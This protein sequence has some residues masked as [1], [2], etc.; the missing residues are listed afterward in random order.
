MLLIF[1][2]ETITP[3]RI[4]SRAGKCPTQGAS[5]ASSVEPSIVKVLPD[6]ASLFSQAIDPESGEKICERSGKCR[7]DFL[8]AK[9]EM[10]EK[11]HR[12]SMRE[13]KASN[14]TKHKA[15]T[16]WKTQYGI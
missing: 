3:N 11:K 1:A 13:R 7:F 4:R 12:R 5:G 14:S 10:I 8:R 6:L 15:V 16:I 2:D 9:T